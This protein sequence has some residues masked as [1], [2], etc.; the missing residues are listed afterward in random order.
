MTAS[1]LDNMH[2]SVENCVLYSLY[3]YILSIEIYMD[4]KTLACDESSNGSISDIL[5][6]HL[7][8]IN[9]D[10]LVHSTISQA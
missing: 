7:H 10:Y 5:H 4:L 6:S 3:F 2:F 9:F 1:Y 8:D